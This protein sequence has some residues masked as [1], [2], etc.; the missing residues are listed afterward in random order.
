M[1]RLL[2][3][4]LKPHHFHKYISLEERKKTD[5]MIER[6]LLRIIYLILAAFIYLQFNWIIATGYGESQ[7][8]SKNDF[9]APTLSRFK[10]LNDVTLI[11][12]NFLG[13][14][15]LIFINEHK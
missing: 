9:F 3:P 2:S 4:L 14:L 5:A 13:F 11:I 12:Q 7:F 10:I 8:I 15:Q 1:Y 6:N